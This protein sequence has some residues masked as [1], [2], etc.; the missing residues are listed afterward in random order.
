MKLLHDLLSLR[1]VA[2]WRQRGLDVVG[3]VSTREPTIFSLHKGSH[4]FVNLAQDKG[5][6]EVT[7]RHL[8]RFWRHLVDP[9]NYSRLSIS[10]FIVNAYVK[11]KP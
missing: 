4:S 8:L 10:C 2:A 9:V 6:T 7:P 11:I 3:G 1:L 5:E